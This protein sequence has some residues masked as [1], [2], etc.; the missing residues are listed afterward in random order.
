MKKRITFQEL[1]HFQCCNGVSVYGQGEQ[2]N[3]KSEPGAV[4]TGRI[5]R[6]FKHF[7]LLA[8]I[9]PLSPWPV[10]TAPGS[11]FVTNRMKFESNCI[12]T[13]T[14]FSLTSLPP[15][16]IKSRRLAAL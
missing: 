11:D 12:T 5:L 4:A 1:M 2:A 9:L 7:V 15:F 8:T 10:A 14:V 13:K 6:F 3:T 16:I